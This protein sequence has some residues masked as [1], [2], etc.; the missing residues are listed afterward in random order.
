MTDTV[1]KSILEVVLFA[2]IIRL[3]GVVQKLYWVIQ[4]SGLEVLL[5]QDERGM[6]KPISKAN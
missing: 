3:V 4:L 5:G 2:P 6:L 1:R